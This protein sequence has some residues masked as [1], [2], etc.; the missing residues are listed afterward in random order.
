MDIWFGMETLGGLVLL[1]AENIQRVLE[2]PT[3]AAE[4]K[5]FINA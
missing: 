2:S 1:V 5:H 4:C 3:S